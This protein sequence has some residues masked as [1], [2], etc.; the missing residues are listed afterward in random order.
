MAAAVMITR[1]TIAAMTH[2]IIAPVSLLNAVL[3]KG[4]LV[5]KTDMLVVLLLNNE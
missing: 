3:A 1:D 4:E 5:G 2:P